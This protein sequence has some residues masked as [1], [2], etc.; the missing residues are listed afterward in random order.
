M[1]FSLLFNPIFRVWNL[2]LLVLWTISVVVYLALSL[3][4]GVI[5]G[6]SGRL[7]II[8]AVLAGFCVIATHHILSVFQWPFRGSALLDL[9]FTFVELPGTILL[10]LYLGFAGLGGSIPLIISAV[11]RIATI[12]TTPE[13]FFRQ[14]FALLGRCTSV[15]PPYTPMHIFLNRSM[16][17]PLVRGESRPI[18]FIRA[19]VIWCIGLGV[20]LFAVYSIVFIPITTQIYSKYVS[21]F[22]ST[23]IL[24]GPVGNASL[25]LVSFP[26][27]DVGVASEV[28]IWTKADLWTTGNHSSCG[29]KSSINGWENLIQC[30]ML[31]RSLIPREYS[32]VLGPYEWATALNI[33]ISVSL[34]PGMTGVNVV[35]VQGAMTDPN[36][37]DVLIEW[38]EN[39]GNQLDGVPLFR[40]SNLVGT[41]TWAQ[42][43]MISSTGWS[44][45]SQSNP[46]GGNSDPSHATLTLVQ[47]TP[48]VT[49]HFVDM[50]DATVL[51]G[52]ATFGGFWTFLNGAFALFFGA[53]VLY[54]AFGRRPLSA[55][56]L[57]HMFQRRRLKR[58]WDEDFPTIHT[59]GGRPGSESAGIVAFIRERLVDLGEDPHENQAD[60]PDDVEGQRTRQRTPGADEIHETNTLESLPV[61][62]FESRDRLETL[63]TGYVLDEIPLLNV[64]LGLDEMLK[65]QNAV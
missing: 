40:G 62:R 31:H 29:T 11:F 16:T 56:G 17:R 21:P 32:S 18:L 65:T 22:H 14:R 1:R 25:F 35:P 9:V 26:F 50:A 8:A 55:L 64:D 43:D 53:N 33:S 61:P 28:Q 51:N 27:N 49:K 15:H 7:A 59:E 45:F 5:N 41:F 44:V 60:Q 10:N 39:F 37:R 24:S 6:G 57:V 52:I 19:C 20:P 34:P 46:A 54:F 3:C 13:R 58:Q 63:G 36:N 2:R 48:L 30:T 12:T 47:T 42:T 4:N 38:L 23:H